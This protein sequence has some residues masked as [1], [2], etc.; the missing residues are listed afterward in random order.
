MLAYVLVL[1]VELRVFC[2]TSFSQGFP[3]Y[4]PHNRVEFINDSST[5]ND[6]DI[7]ELGPNL[8][9]AVSGVIPNATYQQLL[10]KEC[11]GAN[12]PM[13]FPGYN[14]PDMPL[15]FYLSSEPLTYSLSL[16]ALTQYRA[17][18]NTLN[19]CNIYV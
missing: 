7:S 8:I 3:P 14:S 17:F 15:F 10:E 9:V 11:Y 5:P 4:Y 12:V 13:D 16:L 19:H 6:C 18:Y 1:K 2:H